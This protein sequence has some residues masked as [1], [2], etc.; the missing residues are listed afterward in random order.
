LRRRT[1]LPKISMYIQRE[2]S[3]CYCNEL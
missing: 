1:M 2:A 3:K